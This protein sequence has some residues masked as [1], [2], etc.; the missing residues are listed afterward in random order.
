MRKGWPLSV[1][2]WVNTLK[3]E[4]YMM[5]ALLTTLE[6]EGVVRKNYRFLREFVPRI[7]DMAG[8]IEQATRFILEADQRTRGQQP[9]WAEFTIE[10]QLIANEIILDVRQCEAEMDVQNWRVVAFLLERCVMRCEMI[11]TILR[12]ISTPKRT[13]NIKVP[14]AFDDVDFTNQDRTNDEKHNKPGVHQSD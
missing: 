3:H 11:E 9:K 4:R 2:D 14:K 5:A 1:I 13:P 12:P 8:G 7:A 6:N 10:A